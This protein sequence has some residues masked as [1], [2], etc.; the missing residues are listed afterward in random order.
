MNKTNKKTPTLN[1]KS[2]QNFKKTKK[3]RIHKESNLEA[4]YFNAHLLTVTQGMA[5]GLFIL[6]SAEHLL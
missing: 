1:Q 6:P 5:V 4:S 3:K 2:N